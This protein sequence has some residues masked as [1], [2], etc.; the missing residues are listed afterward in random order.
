MLFE[1]SPQ[2]VKDLKGQPEHVHVAAGEMLMPWSKKAWPV[3]TTPGGNHT[4]LSAAISLD[5]P[6]ADIED[7]INSEA[8]KHRLARDISE[9]LG[10]SVAV[11]GPLRIRAAQAS[12][13]KAPP[14]RLGKTKDVRIA[15]SE[16]GAAEAVDDGIPW[17]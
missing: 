13:V 5:L 7:K 11:T 10:D 12:M 4:Y 9:T 15:S 14:T 16:V 17:A 6:E 8:F 1:I 3:A 2:G